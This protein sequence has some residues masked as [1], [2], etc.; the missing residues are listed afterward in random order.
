MQHF[1]RFRYNNLILRCTC[2]V[3]GDAEDVSRLEGT[4]PRE[5]VCDER[6]HSAI[7]QANQPT[8]WSN[9]WKV[10]H[11]WT[12]FYILISYKMGA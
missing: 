11:K 4:G 12:K 10:K 2:F 6:G 3:S 9:S 8:V 5:A 1:L 7:H